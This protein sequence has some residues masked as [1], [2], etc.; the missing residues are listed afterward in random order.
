VPRPA[1]TF[2]RFPGWSDKEK[3]MKQI[4]ICGNFTAM[5]RPA[6]TR[7]QRSLREPRRES[8]EHHGGGRKAKQFAKRIR[9]NRI[10]PA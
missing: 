7:S 4:A 6:I 8:G 2:Y 9:K 10:V 1:K 3:I 5:R